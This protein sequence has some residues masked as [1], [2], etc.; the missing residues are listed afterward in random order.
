[1]TQS[2]I[3]I[4][5]KKKYQLLLIASDI[6]II[7]S[8]AAFSYFFRVTQATG[9]LVEI[10]QD[11]YATAS[12]SLTISFFSILWLIFLSIL[13]TRGDRVIGAGAREYALVAQA[14]LLTFSISIFI[15]FVINASFSRQIILTFFFFGFV[16]LVISRWLWRRQL[17]RLRRDSGWKE[18][19]VLVGQKKEVIKLGIELTNRYQSGF[20]LAGVCLTDTAK[21]AP[22]SLLIQGKRIRVFGDSNNVREAADQTLSSSV[23]ITDRNNLTAIQIKDISW[24]LDPEKHE[25]ILAQGLIDISGPRIHTRPVAGL[26]L[27]YVEVPSFQGF[28]RILK[29][30]TD[31]FGSLL[32]LLVFAIPSLLIATAIKLTSHGPIFFS[33]ERVGLNNTRFKMYKFRTMIPEAEKKKTELLNEHDSTSPLFKIIDDPRVTPIG[34][35]L[36][37]WSLDE[38]PQL[39]NVF[40][41]NMSL[42][43]PRPPLQSEVDQYDPHVNRKFL[44]K[45][46]ITGLWQISG[47]S[48]LSW[49]D[50]VRLDLYYVENWS[51]AT[52]IIILFRTVIS[53]LK[54]DGA[55]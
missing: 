50:S 42:V 24:N 53:V 54:R 9:Y 29:R 28:K 25:L 11:F 38:L 34:K 32:G 23:I 40:I 7:F 18:N 2:A 21:N 10:N 27:M 8:V 5:W 43:G 52:D 44:V 55:Y 51:F 16:F 36:R 41:G 33:Q 22:N 6:V 1:M 37:K 15:L 35:F 20:E 45:P 3:H 12:Y 4:T 47:R 19:V 17:N 49:E 39:L 14:S 48:N 30:L 26:P 13:Q 46:G 31:I